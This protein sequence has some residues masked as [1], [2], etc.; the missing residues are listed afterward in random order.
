MLMTAF[1]IMLTA[2]AVTPLYE[3]APL[4]VDTYLRGLHA[5][6]P[7]FAG[8]IIDIA[9]RSLGTPYHGDPLGEGPSGKVDQ[10]P[11]MDLTRVDCVTFVEQTIALASSTTYLDALA[12]LQ[13]IRYRGSAVAFEQRNHFMTADW[14]VNNAFCRPIS[15]ELGVQSAKATRTIGRK[16][17]FELKE[18]P[19]CAAEAENPVLT[20]TYV[21]G[22]RAAQAA[23]QLPSPAL[24][25]LIGKV[26]WLFALH[27]GLHIRD[28]AGVSHLYHAS[29]KSEA[30][31]AV[32]FA[33]VFENT[34]RYIGFA[35]YAI[36]PRTPGGVL[37][38]A[39][40]TRAS[41]D[42]AQPR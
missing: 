3:M 14:V 34:A 32:D 22:E 42:C 25:L 10:E 27:C 35:A 2:T 9:Q 17:F 37:W 23:A 6:E 15:A 39:R 30:V 29:S 18:L 26:D 7:S 38:R 16:Y 4:E 28:D 11:L 40:S 41:G 31:V 19:D 21:P 24:I 5:A 8:R 13:R 36:E 20:L 33:E 1:A 12:N